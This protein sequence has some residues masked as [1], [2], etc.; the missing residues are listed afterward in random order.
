ME[1]VS[2]SRGGYEVSTKV[3]YTHKEIKESSEQVQV[4]TEPPIER[5]EF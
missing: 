2:I 5:A 4:T 3:V 1:N